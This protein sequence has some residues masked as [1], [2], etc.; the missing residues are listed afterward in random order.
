MGKKVENIYWN[1][2]SVGTLTGPSVD[3]FDYYGLWTPCTDENLYTSFLE[4]VQMEGGTLVA[5]GDSSSDL[6]G[7]VEELPSDELQIKLRC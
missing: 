5:I 1:G 7:T 3:M 4:A 6:V 2:R